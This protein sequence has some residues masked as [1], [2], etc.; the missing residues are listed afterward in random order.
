MDS[1]GPIEV[2]GG[3]AVGRADVSRPDAWEERP[4][5]RPVRWLCFLGVA[6]PLGTEVP[7]VS[8]KVDA[9]YLRAVR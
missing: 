4:Q 1:V 7:G 5:R 6:D 2:R 8:S 9:A 3:A